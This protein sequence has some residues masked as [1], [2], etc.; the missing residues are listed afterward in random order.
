MKEYIALS[1]GC[2]PIHIGHI[3][4]IQAARQFGKVLFLLNSDEW[5]MRKKGFVFMTF[6]ERKE[7]LSSIVDRVYHVDDSDNTVC[8][9][10][11]V[12]EHEILAFGK[13]GDRGPNNTP[14]LNVCAEL[15]I[16]VIFGLGGGKIQSS[17]NLVKNAQKSTS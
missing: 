4:Y 1:G 15:G 2:D 7:I 12:K 6:Y 5:L 9:G 8:K 16:P 11:I 3:R 17:S 13:G 10:I 14:E